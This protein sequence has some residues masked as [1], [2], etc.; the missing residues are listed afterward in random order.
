MSKKPIPSK[1]DPATCSHPL[2]SRHI[3]RQA[4]KGG[5]TGNWVCQ[6]CKQEFCHLIPAVKIVPAHSGAALEVNSTIM[7]PMSYAGDDDDDH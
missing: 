7:W 6:R 4:P 1:I 5:F 3:D 2:L